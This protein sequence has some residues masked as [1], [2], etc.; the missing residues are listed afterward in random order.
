MTMGYG[1]T[2]HYKAGHFQEGTLSQNCGLVTKKQ[3][4]EECGLS[5]LF[6][7]PLLSW[8]TQG[9]DPMSWKVVVLKQGFPSVGLCFRF[10]TGL[11][12]IASS[13]GLLFLVI[14]DFAYFYHI[15]VH[16]RWHS[17]ALGSEYSMPLDHCRQQTSSLYILSFVDFYCWL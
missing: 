3:F 8:A 14:K 9:F 15:F 10:T 4:R 6:I 1:D 11:L 7:C 17:W 2:W 5:C 16:V 12:Q 13:C